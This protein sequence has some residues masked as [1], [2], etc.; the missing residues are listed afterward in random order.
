MTMQNLPH[1]DDERLAA[2]AGGDSDAVA[3]RALAAHL[4][5]C[6]RCR[7]LVDELSLLRDALSVLPDLVPSRPL[8]LIPPA[9]APAVAGGSVA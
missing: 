7:P 9:P 5:A 4:T 3:D 1:P 8:R 2:Y 6:D